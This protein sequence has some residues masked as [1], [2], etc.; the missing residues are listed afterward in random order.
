MLSFVLK[1]GKE[2]KTNESTVPTACCLDDS[3]SHSCWFCGTAHIGILDTQKGQ[4]EVDSIMTKRMTKRTKESP[5]P[6]IEKKR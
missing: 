6:K 2:M 5:M 3:N 4:I 1:G